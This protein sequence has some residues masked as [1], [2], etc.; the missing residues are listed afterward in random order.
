MTL[1][2]ERK[3][4]DGKTYVVDCV[5]GGFAGWDENGEMVILP[6][7]VLGSR[8][9]G[10]PVVV[11]TRSWHKW[12]APTTH[13]CE[14]GLHTLYNGEYEFVT[15]HGYSFCWERQY[16]GSTVSWDYRER[17]IKWPNRTTISPRQ[18]FAFRAALQALFEAR[19]CSGEDG[20]TSFMMRTEE[21]LQRIM[22]QEDRPSG[23][24][25]DE[26]LPNVDRL[27]EAIAARE[28][29]LRA[30]SPLHLIRDLQMAQVDAAAEI[31][32]RS[33]SPN[34]VGDD[35]KPVRGSRSA[36]KRILRSGDE[37]SRFA[38]TVLHAET[39]G[40]LRA[41]GGIDKRYGPSDNT[42]KPKGWAK[43][44]EE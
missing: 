42:M 13:D 20:A 19:S 2:S 25:P 21:I 10:L 22:R 44:K 33:L 16:S 30:K 36:L 9:N 17:Y 28:A 27:D 35:G 1:S 14:F 31:L 39:Y 8:A 32:R 3:D 41:L 38:A 37:G 43:R 12:E 6:D 11:V 34:E 23:H 7:P 18:P 29:L 40:A 5:L 26:I 4:E 24:R 15:E